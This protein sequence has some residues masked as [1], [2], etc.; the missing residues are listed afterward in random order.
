M[1][2]ENFVGYFSELFTTVVTF[3]LAYSIIKRDHKYL[4]NLLIGSGV[5]SIGGYTL[6]IFIYD[7]AATPWVI[8]LFL[9]IGMS[10]IMFGTL[11]LYF[12]F[13]VLNNSVKWFDKK[14]RWIP[15][16]VVWAIYTVWI[17]ADQSLLHIESLAPVKTQFAVSGLAIMVLFLFFFLIKTMIE[18][19]KTLKIV[20]GTMNKRLKIILYGIIV[21]I[22]A[23]VEVI[24]AHLFE[25]LVVLAYVFF[26]IICIGAAIIAY[27]FLKKFPDDDSVETQEE[28]EELT[29]LNRTNTRN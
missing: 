26:Y 22:F 24:P 15:Y 29:V 7:I 25:G 14:R 13:Q 11:C 27:A 10:W 23:I 6:C 8:H 4:G 20:K 9:P 16:L 12:G 1:N 19:V 21:M 3:F 2:F 28:E 5:A 17:L 18:I